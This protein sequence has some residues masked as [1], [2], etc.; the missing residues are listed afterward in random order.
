MIEFRELT[1]I[2]DR[3]YLEYNQ[4]SNNHTETID[5]VVSWC[6]RENVEIETLAAIVK[7]NT[8]FKTILFREAKTLNFLKKELDK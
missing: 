2:Q 6:L 8:I 1:T 5:F 4:I 7:S 3:F